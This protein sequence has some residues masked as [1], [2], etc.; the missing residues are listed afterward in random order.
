[1]ASKTHAQGAKI[2]YNALPIAAASPCME[3]DEPR[4]LLNQTYKPSLFAAADAFQG[5]KQ[6]EALI[7]TYREEDPLD[8]GPNMEEMR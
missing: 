1:M 7:N 8:H 3:K 6:K 4:R 2:K 5:G